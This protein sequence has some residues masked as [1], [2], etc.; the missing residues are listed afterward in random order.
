MRIL[1][2]LTE[3]LGVTEGGSSVKGFSKTYRNFGQTESS[4][5][6]ASRSSNGSDWP[7]KLRRGV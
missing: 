7:A 6:A 5:V 4:C 2:P 1:L 3:K